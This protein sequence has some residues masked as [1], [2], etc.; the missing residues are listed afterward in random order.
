MLTVIANPKRNERFTRFNDKI[1]AYNL[2]LQNQDT[3]LAL[4]L[5]QELYFFKQHLHHLAMDNLFD[6][7]LEAGDLKAI[8]DWQGIQEELAQWVPGGKV[9]LPGLSTEKLLNNLTSGPEAASSTIAAWKTQI[10]PSF[11]GTISFLWG[12]GSNQEVLA[13]ITQLL[14]LH[15]TPDPTGLNYF[16]GLQQ[17]KTQLLHNIN[18]GTLSATDI[19]QYRTLLNQINGQINEVIV[20]NSMLYS[21]YEHHATLAVDLRRN[22]ESAS[23]DDKE[24]IFGILNSVINYTHTP[25]I[26]EFPNMSEDDFLDFVTQV[27]THQSTVRRV[28]PAFDERYVHKLAGTNNKT[29]LLQRDEI[30]ESIVLRVEQPVHATLIQS[31][32]ETPVNEFLSQTYATHASEYNPYPFVLSEFAEGGDMRSHCSKNSHFLNDESR[33]QQ[34][35]SDLGQMANFCKSMLANGAMHSDLKLSNILRKANGQI[36]VNDMKAFGQVDATGKISV[37]GMVVT[38]P[39]APP[40]Y[41]AA[42]KIQKT[43]APPM[44]LDADK[45]MSYQLGLALYDY[46][47]LPETNEDDELCWSQKPLDFTH[48]VFETPMGGKLRALIKLLTLPNSDNR[49]NL[50]YAI[51]QLEALQSQAV[52]LHICLN[53]TEKPMNILKTHTET[54]P[55][56]E[57][58]KVDALQL[59]PALTDD[60]EASADDRPSPRK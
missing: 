50:D 27:Q 49:K 17:V 9:P 22:F 13:Y 6:P 28:L 57:P 58:T 54:D 18:F 51:K 40:E 20:N 32:R 5:L 48:P 19:I 1:E 55:T 45:F 3:P 43:N 7:Q 42:R 26:L 30:A 52:R 24:A 12:G 59:N 10:Q 15:E 34:A 23:A 14:M 46:L 37:Q 36:I 31:L 21:R 33:V 39:F 44:M 11:I 2:A 35:V 29:W 53:V 16:Y 47:V 38:P 8:F 56:A 25:N 41:Y 60:Q 4:Q